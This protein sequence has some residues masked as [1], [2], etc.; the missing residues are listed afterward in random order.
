MFAIECL[1][2]TLEFLELTIECLVFVIRCLEFAID[3]KEFAIAIEGLEFTVRGLELKSLRKKNV[4]RLITI[5]SK[6][7][8]LRLKIFS[9]GQWRFANTVIKFCRTAHA[10]PK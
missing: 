8:A 2:L 5:H 4:K 9:M 1:I 7:L 3:C 10:P 6:E